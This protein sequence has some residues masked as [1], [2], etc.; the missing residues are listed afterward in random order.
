MSLL[1]RATFA[2]LKAYSRVTPTERGGF[3]LARLARRT[4]PR[5]RWKG[6]FTTPGQLRLELDLGTYPDVCMAFGLYERDTERVIRKILRP[7]MHFVDI[8]ANIGYFT[9]LAAKLVGPTGRVDAFEPDPINRARLVRHVGENGFVEGVRV[10]AVGVGAEAG[11]V[12]LYHPKGVM[13]HGSASIFQSV[14]GESDAYSIDIARADQVID[15]IP[16]LIKMD[17]EGAELLAIQGMTG[18]LKGERPPAMIIE[19][20]HE[21]A[22]A[23]GH[24]MADIFRTLTEAQP[25]YNVY[26]IGTRLTRFSTPEA[27][28]AMARQGNILVTVD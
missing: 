22:R 20:N 7:G 5:E 28:E 13:N 3:R 21:T 4:L 18:L 19:H 11:T 24:S 6:M 9:V 2:V 23:G 12:T 17:I 27:L 15:H 16:D 26:W 14:V 8:G 10:H 25:R 1:A